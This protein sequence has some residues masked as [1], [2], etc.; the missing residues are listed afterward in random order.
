MERQLFSIEHGIWRERDVRSTEFDG[1]DLELDVIQSL[2][3]S[4][5]RSMFRLL[6]L[7]SSRSSRVEQEVDL[8][9]A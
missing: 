9:S 8:R 7:V 4:R 6:A 2:D 1:A 3:L 5:C